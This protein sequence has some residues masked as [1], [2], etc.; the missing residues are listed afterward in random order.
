VG[1]AGH[2][3][4]PADLP[5]RRHRLLDRAGLHARLCHAGRG[6]HPAPDLE[7]GFPSSFP[8]DGRRD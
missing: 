5:L 1:P 7:G 2:G 4:R 8:D 3:D 6:R